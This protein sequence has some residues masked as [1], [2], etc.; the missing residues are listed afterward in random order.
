MKYLICFFFLIICQSLPA[1]SVDSSIVKKVDSLLLVSKS[2]SMK[3][4]FEEALKSNSL[5]EELIHKELGEKCTSF[6]TA[7]FNRGRIYRFMGKFQDAEIWYIKAL[8]LR[9]ELLGKTHPDYV[10]NQYNLGLLYALMAKYKEGEE[11]LMQVLT[12]R[13]K[14]LGTENPDYI[15]CL[16]AVVDINYK[17]GLFKKAMVYAE[18]LR[19]TRE[20]IKGIDHPDY[21]IALFWLALLNDSQGKYTLGEKLLLQAQAIQ[22]KTIGTKHV[23]YLNTSN[24]LAIHYWRLGLYEKAEPLIR[25]TVNTRKEILGEESS[26]YIRSLSNLGILYLQMGNYKN[27]EKIFKE[28][29][30]ILGKTAGK[31]H[32]DYAQALSNLANLYLKIGEID[33][34]ESLFLESQAIFE[35]VVGKESPDYA[36]ILYNL[37]NIYHEKGQFQKAETYYLDALKIREKNFGTENPDVANS[38]YSLGDFYYTLKDSEKAETYLTKSLSLREKIFGKEHPDYINSLFGLGIL[39]LSTKQYEKSAKCFS[40][41]ATL[42]KKL[43]GYSCRHLSEQELLAYLSTFSAR[44][45]EMLTFMNLVGD[46]APYFSATCYDNALF[47]KGFLLQA[48]EIIK[49]LARNNPASFE[50]FQEL[51]LLQKQMSAELTKPIVSRNSAIISD[52]EK[53]SNELEK[54][55][56]KMVSGFEDIN[57]QINWQQVQKTLK[58]DEASIEFVSFIIEGKDHQ[59]STLYAALMVKPNVQQP[60]FIALF[61]EKALDTILN[62]KSERKADYVNGLYTLAN[63]GAVVIES[64]KKSLYDLLWYPLEKELRGVKTIYF[65]PTGLLHRINIDAIPVSETETL[66]DQYKLIE[67]ISTRQLALNNQKDNVNNTSMLFGGIQ[68]E[69][70]TLTQKIEPIFASRAIDEPIFSK[71]DSSLRGG[72]WNYLAG[73]EREVN[74]IEKIMQTSGFNV[75]LYKAYQ[76][77]EEAFKNIGTNNSSSPRILHIATHGYFFPD[78]KVNS[79]KSGFSVENESVF[80]TSD[81]PMLRS[82]LI[83]AGGNA[84][85]QGKQTME[86]R[87]DGI[88]TAYEISQMNLSN[89]ELVV[90]SACETG[91]GDIQ[92]NEGVYGLQRAFKIAGARYLIMSLWQVPDKQTSLLMTT[93]YKKWLEDKMTIPDAFHAAQRELREIGLDPYQWAGFVLVE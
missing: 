26:L 18:E 34:V 42:D 59:D 29:I 1:Q 45:N 38:F 93:F 9:E 15:F 41:L 76:G 58:S 6:A 74:S 36:T 43:L 37:A 92:G 82:G 12:Y 85:W 52:I 16:Q 25:H 66:A 8:K 56:A 54:E 68:F 24:N 32:P 35:K 30:T 91:L 79:K 33:K 50:R 65:S 67:L 72:T 75:S 4:N 21:A 51:N 31:D 13:S 19:S 44:Q 90:L 5:A 22:A 39:Y 2:F 48:N 70:D 14:N 62:S 61:E 28:A 46:H 77:T 10:H 73:T 64:E 86:G 89:T 11:L 69:Q 27:A 55:I 53:Q 71:G 78:P 81:H 3:N 40:E 57:Q 60:I 49:N 17:L 23:D 83:M 88:L 80:K 47:F 20:K 63:R 7:C 87:E 84:S